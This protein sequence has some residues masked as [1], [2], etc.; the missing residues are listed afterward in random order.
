MSSVKENFRQIGQWGFAKLKNISG[1][2]F[3]A[4]LLFLAMTA[5]YNA[6]IWRMGFYYD[7]WEGVLLQKG[8][9]SFRQIWE[10]FLRDR[11][12]STLVH[13]LYNPLI[14][15]APVGWRILGQSLNFAAV[16]LLV[17]TLLKIWPKRVMEIGWIG[18]LLAIYPG[19][20]RQ[21]VIRTSIPHYTSLFLF[22]LSLLFMV[23]AVLE[24][25]R[26]TLFTVISVL[27]GI[28]QML[29]IEYFVG[30]ELVRPLLLFY[31]ARKS[32]P[33][34]WKAARAALL[35]WLPY[36]LI[37]AIFLF[38]YFGILP[39]IQVSGGTVKNNL[40]I[41]DQLSKDLVG[42]IM[43]TA[44]II[45]QDIV[46]AV[47]YVWPQ[48]VVPEQF[49]FRVRTALFAWLV[50]GLVAVLCAIGVAFWHRKAVP[51]EEGESY[52]FLIL[53]ICAAALLF[54][55]API[56]AAGRQATKG[57]WS[58][59]YLFGPVMGAVPLVVL[60]V[61]WLTGS[62]RR[63][64]MSIFLA[65]LLAGAVSYQFQTAQK[66]ALTWDYE[67]DYYWQ[68]KWRAPS[69]KPGVFILAPETPFSYNAKY[70]IAYAINVLY[71][72]G[73]SQT[74]TRYWWIYGPGEV[75]DLDT[76]EYID[77]LKIDITM[78]NLTFQSDK[79]HALPVIYRPSRGCLLVVSQPYRYQPEMNFDETQLFDYANDGL[80]G[81]SGSEVPQDVFGREPEH[82]WCYYFQKADLARELKQW[83]KVAALWDSVVAQGLTPSYAAEYAPF[84]ESSLRT[85]NWEQA[86]QMT[87]IANETKDMAPLLC[88]NWSRV[89]Q[90]LP[91]SAE[92]KDHWSII[93]N[94][95]GCEAAGG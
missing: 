37:F 24:P 8:L 19:I 95:L 87:Q 55:G 29:I 15:A 65:V 9:F 80:V 64:V 44:N 51:E 25:R 81:E 5:A 70:Q 86:V 66:Y 92:K 16:L 61:S 18:L 93:K 89:L 39:G 47:V 91:D 54:G 36:G 42:G 50:G 52:P 26:R 56:W 88:S 21:F 17:K 1:F 27:L 45:Y 20:T 38:F 6:Q 60:F 75:R 32:M 2:R 73:N 68:L 23:K 59:R 83:D 40:S 62:G 78:R 82:G 79:K 14:G 31:I 30:L 28:L 76:L 4:L 33:S 48:V 58:S 10:Y 63:R 12:F 53:L 94:Q 11:P 71:A 34:F 90:D 41:V 69:L 84:I 49:D 3:Y 85:G 74:N 77:D 57:I 35:A 13:W 46:Y 43:N 72:P 22:T 67:R 7:D